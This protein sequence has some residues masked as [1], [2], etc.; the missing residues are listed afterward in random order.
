YSQG[1]DADTLNHT[2]SGIKRITARAD[3]RVKMIA[4]KFA[5]TGV[6][7]LFRLIQKL[8]MQHQDKPMAIAVSQGKWVD[9][10]PRVWRNEYSMKVV[11][12]TG[13]GDMAERVGS[14]TQ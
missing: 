1:L 8:L 7:D 6:T 2:A 12:G 10:D 9:I 5:E 14:L 4:R 11:V 13:T 3:L